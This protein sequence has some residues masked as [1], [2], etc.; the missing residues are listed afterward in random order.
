MLWILFYKEINFHFALNDNLLEKV[1]IPY[2]VEECRDD[3]FEHEEIQMLLQISGDPAP[4][5]HLVDFLPPCLVSTICYAIS[6]LCLPQH[7]NYLLGYQT[8]VLFLSQHSGN[9][10]VPWENLCTESSPPAECLGENILAPTFYL[11]Y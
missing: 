1:W 4:V 9:K 11:A 5:S 8:R 6:S 10:C 3:P 2:C 7:K